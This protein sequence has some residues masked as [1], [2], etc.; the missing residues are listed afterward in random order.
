MIHRDRTFRTMKQARDPLE[1]PFV[2]AWLHLASIVVAGSV[3]LVIF[4]A[5]A[6]LRDQTVPVLVMTRDVVAL[7]RISNDDLTTADI[8]PTPDLRVIFGRNRGSVVGRI[9][10][11]AL[12]K[13]TVLA[14]RDVM[15]AYSL[16]V[17][18]VQ[19]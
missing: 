9:A 5:V 12:L 10:A 17:M 2:R 14:E 15:P 7:S 6:I 8:V 11:T 13:G 1:S 16:A 4:H 3:A 18:T 19:I